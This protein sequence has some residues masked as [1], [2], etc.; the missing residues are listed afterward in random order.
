MAITSAAQSGCWQ[1]ILAPG[2]LRVK[3]GVGK[4]IVPRDFDP[5][6]MAIVP[7]KDELE[8]DQRSS[9]LLALKWESNPDIRRRARRLE[10]VFFASILI[11][12]ILEF[13]VHCF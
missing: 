9:S 1:P 13:A 5:N 11:F 8:N 4:M 10:L 2:H 3:F 7:A 12:L 6:A